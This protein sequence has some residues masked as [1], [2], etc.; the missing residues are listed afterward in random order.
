MEKKFYKNCGCG[1]YPPCQR[2]N[3]TG[4]VRDR[5]TELEYAD[6][7]RDRDRDDR[8]EREREGR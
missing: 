2:C 4:R 8:L 5:D 6:Y 1:G 7:C 3:G